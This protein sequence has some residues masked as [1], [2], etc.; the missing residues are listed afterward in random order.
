MGKGISTIDHEYIVETINMFGGD[1]EAAAQVLEVA[2]QALALHINRTPKLRALFLK[3]VARLE[4]V[5]PDEVGQIFRDIDL[6]R[7]MD[8]DEQSEIVKNLSVQNIDLLAD[9]LERNG[10]KKKTVDKLKS[11]GQIDRSAASFLVGS[12]DMMH[13]MVVY[14]GVSLMEQAEEIKENYL[15][16]QK[17]IPMKERIVWQRLYNQ[18]VDQMGR[19][20]DRVLAGTTAMVKITSPKKGD[21]KAK[22]K[23]GF[24][25]LKKAGK[26]A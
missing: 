4:N 3:D 21:D 19:S 8:R 16:P 9:G 26:D 18:V 15:D 25:P 20:Y 1:I 13:R 14:Q 12:L 7:Q 17:N 10:I 22:A 11:L 24:R 2:P 6:P 23:P 5:E